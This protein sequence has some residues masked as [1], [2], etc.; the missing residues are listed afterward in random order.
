MVR[1]RAAN[2]VGDTID[3]NT[4]SSLYSR[5]GTTQNSTPCLRMSAG[6]TE[7]IRRASQRCCT[8]ACSRR[9]PNGRVERISCAVA[10]VPSAT[11]SISV[12]SVITDV[13]WRMMERLSATIALDD[14]ARESHGLLRAC[15]L[16]WSLEE[17]VFRRE[18]TDETSVLEAGATTGASA[19]QEP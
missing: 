8:S 19:A 9:V 14:C 3:V 1:R 12:L 10:T 5:I 6:S 15:L 13:P 7:S 16:D 11:T 2:V 4:G 18:L 17:D